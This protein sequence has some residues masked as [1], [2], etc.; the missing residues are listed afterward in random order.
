MFSSWLLIAVDIV[1][2]LKVGPLQ[3]N[4]GV[5]TAGLPGNSY[6]MQ[7]FKKI[8]K[9]NTKEIQEE[10]NIKI[11]N[12]IQPCTCITLCAVLCLVASDSL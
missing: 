3:W 10:Q 9:I 7:Y 11:K 4:P 5:P 8:N 6:S 12:R 1:Q 2:E